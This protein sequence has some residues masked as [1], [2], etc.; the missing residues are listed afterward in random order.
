MPKTVLVFGTFDIFHPGH[1]FF[2]KEAKKHGDTLEVVVARDKTVEEV[3]GMAPRNDERKRVFVLQSLD[4]ID[5]VILGSLG[6]K[7]QIIEALEP[8]VICLGYDQKAFT[9][10][11]GEEIKKRGLKAEVIR[12][13]KA[14]EP[15]VFKSSKLRIR[16]E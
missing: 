16:V 3:K 15:E 1:E 7:Y 13:N 8:D 9:D 12:I 6:D 5:E 10:N 14:L 2:L 4:Y 11:L